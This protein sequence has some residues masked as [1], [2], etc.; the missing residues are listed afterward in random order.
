[1]CRQIIVDVTTKATELAF[2]ENK[3]FVTADHLERAWQTVI[4]KSPVDDVREA[5]LQIH[6]K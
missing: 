1:M 2:F 6:K 4:E 5:L 3:K